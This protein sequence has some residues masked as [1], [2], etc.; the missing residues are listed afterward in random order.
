VSQIG[1]MAK[2][3]A[4]GSSAVM[5]GWMFAGTEEAPG[6]YF[7]ENGVRLKRY[8]GMASL[9]AMAAGGDKRYQTKADDRKV[10]VAQGVAGSVLDKGPLNDYVPYLVQGLRQSLQDMGIKSVTALH[11]GLDDGSL[12]FE[13]RSL[14][15]Q[16]EGGV[17]GL[18]SYKDSGVGMRSS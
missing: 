16:I 6:D 13:M 17:H 12:R 18:H 2:A 10:K 14:A 9:E 8:R 5:M 1:H 4:L 3:L 15:A 11:K 7:Y